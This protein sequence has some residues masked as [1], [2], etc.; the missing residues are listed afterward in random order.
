MLKTFKEWLFQESLNI[1]PASK[2]MAARTVW[3]RGR[4]NGLSEPAHGCIW[5]TTDEDTADWY[6]DYEGG[7]TDHFT[8]D[9]NSRVLVADNKIE[10]MAAIWNWSEDQKD[11]L[12]GADDDYGYVNQALGHLGMPAGTR[13]ADQFQNTI[14]L[15]TK[16]GETLRS[17]GIDAAIMHEPYSDEGPEIVVANPKVAKFID[18][19]GYKPKPGHNG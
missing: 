16:I 15:D 4:P 13:P 17:H 2:T 12:Y 10:L 5:G 7:Y 18:R 11:D 8:I 3:K 1:V 9:P 19:T 6:G 14:N